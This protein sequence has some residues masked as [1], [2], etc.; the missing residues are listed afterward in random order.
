MSFS[1]GLFWFRNLLQMTVLSLYV[2]SR[3][4]EGRHL[5]WLYLCIFLLFV[6][7]NKKWSPHYKKTWGPDLMFGTYCSFNYCMI[8]VWQQCRSNTAAHYCFRFPFL[9]S[10]RNR[11]PPPSPALLFARRF[12]TCPAPKC[13]AWPVHC[14]SKSA[15]FSF[16]NPSNK[17]AASWFSSQVLKPYVSRKLFNTPVKYE[18]SLRGAWTPFWEC[19]VSFTLACLT[20]HC[21]WNSSAILLL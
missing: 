9:W 5:M 11:S 2:S 18:V 8:A 13:V 7:R 3:D 6:M 17:Q 19:W 4:F 21:S 15:C 14:R 10:L 20:F 16:Q 12:K 1:K